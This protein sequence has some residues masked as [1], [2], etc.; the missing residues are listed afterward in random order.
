VS[1]G[2]RAARRYV[3]TVVDSRCDAILTFRP[4]PRRTKIVRPSFGGALCAEGAATLTELQSAAAASFI[5]N[6]NG[7]VTCATS[8]AC[9][10][11]TNTKIGAGATGKSAN[12][13]GV[14]GNPRRASDDAD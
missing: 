1:L 5:A 14:V 8:D 7:V 2:V 4:A 6:V 9:V 11:G 10:A 13:F 3:S 12:G